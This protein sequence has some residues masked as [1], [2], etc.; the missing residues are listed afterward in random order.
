MEFKSLC[1]YM[2][3]LSRKQ[4]FIQAARNIIF[5][6]EFDNNLLGILPSIHHNF[7]QTSVVFVVSYK[8]EIFFFS[9]PNLITIFLELCLQYIIIFSRLWSSL[10]SLHQEQHRIDNNTA[11]AASNRPKIAHQIPPKLNKVCSNSKEAGLE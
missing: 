7:Q 1:E 8:H 9:S 2:V 5:L 10:W 4:Q 6:T 11:W 3:T